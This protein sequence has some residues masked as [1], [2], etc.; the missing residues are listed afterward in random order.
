MEFNDGN[1]TP[2]NFD[3]M[4][5]E[6]FGGEKSGDNDLWGGFFKNSGYGKSAYV[7][8]YEKKKKKPIKLLVNPSPE[9]ADTA[10]SRE[11]QTNVDYKSYGGKD[12]QVFYDPVKQENFVKLSMNDI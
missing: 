8:V 12:R 10:P 5:D 2:Y 3:E 4:K 7:L 9:C 1:V 6:C 11:I